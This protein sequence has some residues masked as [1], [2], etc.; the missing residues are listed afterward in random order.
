MPRACSSARPISAQY[1]TDAAADDLDDVR[2]ALGYEQISIYGASYGTRLAQAY[3]RRY[4]QRTRAVVLDAAMP[5]DSKVPLTY[6]ATAQQA[7]DRVFE[8]CAANAACRR[9][10]PNL[11]ADF[12]RLLDR[13]R[14]GP[15]ATSVTPSGRATVPVKMSLGDFGY[16]VRG[17]LYAPRLIEDL[18]DWIGRA[19]AT[20]DVSVF[21][22]RYWERQRAFSRTF[23]TGLHFSVLCSEDVAFI[24]DPEI[25]GATA[26]TFLGRYV[27]DEYRRACALWPKGEL[28][29]DF[30]QPVAVSV[31]TL[32][33]SG[34]FDPVTPPAFAEQIARTLP[35]SRLVVSGQGAHG[36]VAGCPLSAALFVLQSGTTTGV[37]NVCR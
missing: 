19:A 28:A 5:L 22:Q 35:A 2:A 23:A 26:G 9:A 18:P 10:H 20:G 31:P 13:F 17:I 14:A 37:P 24:D 33:V 36:S 7:L 12:A 21:A 11:R 34:A 27:I 15:I 16:A 6:A 8:Q 32:L 4:P 3:M 30:R 29:P 1:T 25:A